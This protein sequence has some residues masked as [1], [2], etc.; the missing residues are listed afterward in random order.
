MDRGRIRVLINGLK[1]LEM[2]LDISSPSGEIKQIELEYEDL[3]KHCFICHSLTHDRNDC[4][5]QRAQANVREASQ[6]RMGISQSRTLDRIEADRRRAS[7]RRQYRTDSS[8]L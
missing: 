7:E 3:Q 6:T 4:P 1:P 2:K 5:S 8:Q